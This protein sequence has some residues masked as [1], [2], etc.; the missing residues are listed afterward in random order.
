MT[1]RAKHIR[2]SRYVPY[3]VPCAYPL[4]GEAPCEMA[5]DHVDRGAAV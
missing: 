2:S 1:N 3:R 5:G 4:V